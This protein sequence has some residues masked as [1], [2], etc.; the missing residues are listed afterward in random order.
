[1][2]KQKLTKKIKIKAR[3]ELHEMLTR[4][5]KKK[6]K[7][8]EKEKYRDQQLILNKHANI[9]F[10]GFLFLVLQFFFLLTESSSRMPKL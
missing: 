6:R 4:N 3:N 8:K 5:T 7:E 2:Q 10:T 1:M 9:F